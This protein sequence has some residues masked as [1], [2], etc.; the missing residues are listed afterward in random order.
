LTH[1]RR[2]D[3]WRESWAIAAMAAFIG[4]SE[5]EQIITSQFSVIPAQ[6]GIHVAVRWGRKHEIK[7]DSR[8]RGNDALL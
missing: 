1:F 7:M 8:L 2:R 3:L 6:A 5:S 4:K